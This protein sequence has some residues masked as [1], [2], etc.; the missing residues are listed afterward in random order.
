MTPAQKVTTVLKEF[1]TIRLSTVQWA[2]IAQMAPRMQYNILALLVHSTQM[3]LRVAQMLVFRAHQESSAD[4][5][6]WMLTLEI[7]KQGGS[8]L[9]VQ[10]RHSL[11]L[12]PTFLL[13]MMFV[14]V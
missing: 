7:V 4:S 6:A 14:H 3:K 5:Q 13:R 8:V 2:T 9:V 10:L 1:R 11:M 12:E